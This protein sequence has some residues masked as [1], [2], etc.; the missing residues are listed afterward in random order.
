MEQRKTFP[1]VAPFCV[2]LIGSIILFSL[3][4]LDKIQLYQKNLMIAVPILGSF[5]VIL[6]FYF[7]LVYERRKLNEI[8]LLPAKRH[9]ALSLFLGLV[10]GTAFFLMTLGAY[11]LRKFPGWDIFL[12]FNLYYL[13]AALSG[14]LVF[15]VW[16]ILSLE[17]VFPPGRVVFL[18][19]IIYTLATLATIGTDSTTMLIGQINKFTVF[20]TI[21]QAFWHGLILALIFRRT[22]CIYGNLLFLFIATIPQVYDIN[23]A[24]QK[25]SFA[26]ACLSIIGLLIFFVLILFSKYIKSPTPGNKNLSE[27]DLC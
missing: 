14:E 18:S 13:F 5:Y 24:A 16:T 10:A 22:K 23:G 2:I 9:L 25:G 19:T 15:R 3:R 27:K 7:L 6:I 26:S 11:P 4:F 12:Q 17:K 21:F 8:G 1:D 20:G